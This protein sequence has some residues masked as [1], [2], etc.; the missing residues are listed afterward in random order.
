[1]SAIVATPP[2]SEP[3]PTITPE[4]SEKKVSALRMTAIVSSV[5]LS[6][7][8]GILGGVFC[9][10]GHPLL[11]GAAITCGACSLIAATIALLAQKLLGSSS[12]TSPNNDQQPPGDPSEALLQP[13]SRSNSDGV[14]QTASIIEVGPP[15][16][17]SPPK[18]LPQH[19][20]QK[21]VEQQGKQVKPSYNV[22]PVTDPQKAPKAVTPPKTF[23]KTALSTTVQSPSKPLPTIPTQASPQPTDITAA[24]PIPTRTPPLNPDQQEVKQGTTDTK[25]APPLKQMPTTPPPHTSDKKKSNQNDSTPAATA[26]PSSQ[27]STP[28]KEELRQKLRNSLKTK[29]QGRLPQSV[30][31]HFKGTPGKEN[32]KSNGRD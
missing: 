11:L 5:A 30:Q 1:M 17:Q 12:K 2:T 7:F 18:A 23:E 32:S 21:P 22:F 3:S 29:Q 31:N 27:E 28:S 16:T 26:P 10:I 6:I 19:V 9:V 20:A 24:S 15:T 13:E 8:S 14:L 25:T 4:S